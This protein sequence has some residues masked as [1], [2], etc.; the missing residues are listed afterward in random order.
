MPS[1]ATPDTARGTLGAWLPDARAAL[2]AAGFS[3]RDAEHLSAHALGTR[4][5]ELWGRLR[6]PVDV[7]ALDAL[8]DRRL[9]GEPLA[10]LLGTQPFRRLE[11]VCGPGVLVPRPETEA[12]VDIALEVAGADPLVI[13]VGTGTGAIA[14]AI[15]DERPGAE[16][17]ATEISADALGYA[18]ENVRRTGLGVR[19]VHGDLFEGLPA[20]L[21][22]RVDLV[23]SNPPYVDPARPDL[24]GPDVAA[25][26]EVA[27][28]G[29]ERGDEVLERIIAEAPEWLAPGGALV[30]E[31]GTGAQLERMRRRL[32][33]W[34]ERGA[35][36][37]HTGRPRVLWART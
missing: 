29:G 24:L 15:A 6:E 9:S 27:L 3:P 21:R 26:P 31:V 18:R 33:G 7:S 36:E 20:E 30:C 2:R 13:D 28:H 37:D 12:V 25:E 19:L 22:G 8:L 1:S 5:G 34:R 17:W 23:V 4:W 14:L 10:Y 32:A 16:V 11:L 35:R